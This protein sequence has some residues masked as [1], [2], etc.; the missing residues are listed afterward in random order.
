MKVKKNRNKWVCH[1]DAQIFNSKEKMEGFFKKNQSQID[2]IKHILGLISNILNDIS[3]QA[4]FSP[5]A[6]FDTGIQKEIRKLFEALT[7]N[8]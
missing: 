2:D 1:R 8:G 3:R 4:E 5:T 6:L 7:S